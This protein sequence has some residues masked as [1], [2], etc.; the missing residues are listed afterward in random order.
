MSE[1]VWREPSV[2]NPAGKA[3]PADLG[4]SG[5]SARAAGKASLARVRP[6]L[7]SILVLAAL[8]PAY[9]YLWMPFTEIKAVQVN[10]AVTLSDSEIMVWMGIPAKTSIFKIDPRNISLAI[11][12]NPRVLNASIAK[13]FPSTLIVTIAEREALALVYA[14]DAQGRISAHCVDA[15]GVV[16][17]A[18]DSDLCRDRLP[19]LSGIEIRGLRYGMRLDDRMLPVLASLEKLTRDNSVLLS[20]ISELRI[21]DRAGLG[22]EVLMY[23]L[24]YRVP[25]RLGA[26]FDAELMKTVLLVLDVVEARG[27]SPNILELDFRNDTFVYRTKEA[28]PG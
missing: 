3:S 27:L 15:Q 5:F 20:G 4:G 2:N 24:H 9:I 10:G 6:V 1:Y 14:R 12:G 25:V 11:M 13:R 16:F 17:A 19:I 28:V 26:D 18:P 21:M 22:I 23:P 7:I 8:I